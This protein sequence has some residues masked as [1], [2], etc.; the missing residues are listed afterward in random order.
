LTP[1]LLEKAL[2]TIVNRHEVLRTVIVEEEGQ[3]YQHILDKDGW[4][5][6]SRRQLR[7]SG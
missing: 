6:G 3:P 1:L 4:E 5:L 2:M 7:L